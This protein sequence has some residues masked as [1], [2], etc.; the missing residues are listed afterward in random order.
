MQYKRRQDAVYRSGEEAVTNLQAAL[1][2]ADLTL[3]SLSN[4]GPVVAMA[5][6]G[7]E[8]ATRTSPTGSPKSSPQV[9]TLCSI[10]G[11]S[12]GHRVLL[13]RG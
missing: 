11:E 1:A 12:P 6:S 8:D 7:S 10:N 2:L 4:D 13:S 3:P 5:S 9:P